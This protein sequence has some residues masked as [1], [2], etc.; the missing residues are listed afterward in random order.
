MPKKPEQT[1]PVAP[2]PT[3]EEIAAQLSAR[4]HEKVQEQERVIMPEAPVAFD[5]SK[6]SPEQLQN[7]KA[8]LDNV[9]N[10]LIR[11]KKANP[12]VTLRTING[13]TVVD[14]SRAFQKLV[15]DPETRTDRPRQHISVTFL[16]EKEPVV[17]SYA[18]FMT[19]E[20]ITCEVVDTHSKEREVEV[21]ETYSVEK[22]VRVPMVIKY[23]D[24][25]FTLKLPDG[26][27]IDVNASKV[28]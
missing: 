7:L 22:K 8:A 6:L 21:G 2:G 18:E 12:T 15:H 1:S 23:I 28:N 27:Q 25:V 3:P 26:Q 11:S 5:F 14:F 4:E 9:P 19:A 16:G 24:R 10:G 17:I 13:K 20:R